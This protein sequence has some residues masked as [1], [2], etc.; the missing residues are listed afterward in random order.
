MH[1]SWSADLVRT[2]RKLPHLCK[3][4]ASAYRLMAELQTSGYCI[5]EAFPFMQVTLIC[6]TQWLSSNL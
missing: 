4:V 6:K 3:Q 5:L 1:E 2:A